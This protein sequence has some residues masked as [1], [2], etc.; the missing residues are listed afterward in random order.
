M[1]TTLIAT[2]NGARTLPEVLKAYCALQPTDGRW[3]LVVVDNGSTDRTSEIIAAYRQHLPLTYLI[4]PK[5]G[6]NAALNTGLTCRA[7]DLLVLTDDDVLP[8]SD[9]L[10]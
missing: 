2:Y 10:R 3:K 9:W 1:L 5:Q 6:K 4:E 8:R 7:G